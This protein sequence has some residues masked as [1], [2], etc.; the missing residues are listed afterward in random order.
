MLSF[1]GSMI[2]LK[3]RS[4]AQNDGHGLSLPRPVSIDLPVVV[5]DEATDAWAALADGT[6]R[7]IFK[8]L[9]GGPMA[10][11]ELASGLPVSRPAVSQHLKV[12]KCA[13]LVSDRAVGRRRVYHVDP[14][15]VDALRSEL[16][17]FWDKAL[18]AFKLIADEG[19]KDG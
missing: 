15:G 13:G 9:A 6:R 3:T 11:G 4:L 8:R 2:A 18:D 17:M 5:T 12:L 7:T 10:V 1:T 14:A 16:D 19:G